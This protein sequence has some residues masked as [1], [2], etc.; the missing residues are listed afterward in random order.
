MKDAQWPRK[1]LVGAASRG[2]PD[3]YMTEIRNV[4]PAG[5]ENTEFLFDLHDEPDVWDDAIETCDAIILTSRGLSGSVLSRARNL[6]F[7]QKLGIASERVDIAACEQAGVAVSVLP[8]AGHM[9]VAEHTIALM[10]ASARG[11]VK[12]H[13]MVAEGYNPLGHE[14]IRTTQD[15]RRVNWVGMGESEFTMLADSTVGLIGFGEIAREVAW[16]ARGLGM[17]VIYTK[18]TPL[19]PEIEQAFG[20]ERRSM[21]DL[22]A[23]AHFVCIHATLPDG[24]PPI[25]GAEQLARMRPDA[26]LINTARGN[27]VDE[28]ALIA[29]L[30]EKRIRG[31]ALD[32]FEVEPL[33]GSELLS[34]PDVI[35]TPHTGA[36]MPLGRRF[37]PALENLAAIGRGDPVAG[38]IAAA[39]APAGQRPV[40]AGSA[41]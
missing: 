5:L 18:R 38:L 19:A 20:V 28:A 23:Q 9:S 13:C 26:T 32:V 22:L 7:V 31:A 16:R 29:A 39:S 41:Q 14:P 37:A 3:Y 2:R 33:I 30:R 17:K 34:F 4:L 8:D 27:Q 15:R 12:S 36:M 6:T 11:L 1:V 10:S 21:D 24:M 35:T 40:H 25:I